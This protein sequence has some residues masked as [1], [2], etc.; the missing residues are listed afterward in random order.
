MSNKMPTP[1]EVE[2]A[3]RNG[4][5]VQPP[6]QRNDHPSAHDLVAGRIAADYPDPDAHSV[7][8]THGLQL[9]LDEMIEAYTN[10]CGTPRIAHEEILKRKAFGLEKYQTLLQPFN[11]RDAVADATDELGDFL[12]Y[13]AVAVYERG[14]LA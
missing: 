7:L 10:L 9:M 3:E 13:L 6:P 5:T 14:N 12:V 8:T 11:G 1:E 4:L 2:M